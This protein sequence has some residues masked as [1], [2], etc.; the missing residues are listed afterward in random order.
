VQIE[1]QERIAIR[2]RGERRENEK[3]KNTE[4]TRSKN[5]KTSMSI[6][7]GGDK[8]IEMWEPI[9]ERKMESVSSQSW[10]NIQRRSGKF[11]INRTSEKKKPLRE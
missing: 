3:K 11:L 2:E 5:I 9:K 6:E 10:V 8:R 4:T 7:S 1:N